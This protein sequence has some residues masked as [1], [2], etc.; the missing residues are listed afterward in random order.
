MGYTLYVGYK[1][2]KENYFKKNLIRILKL[3][4]NFWIILFLF[5]VILWPLMGRGSEYPGDLKTFL[6]TFT[7]I[8]PAYNGAWW[9]LTIYIILVLLSPYINK[10]VIKYNTVVIIGLS[11]I[12]YFAG[13]IQRIMVPVVILMI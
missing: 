11:V 4:I 10:M 12:V 1:N 5:V 8:N 9:F 6:L 13:Y 3:Y 7:A 2:N